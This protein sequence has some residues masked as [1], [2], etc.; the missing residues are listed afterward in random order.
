MGV[1]M[2]WL[3]IFAWFFPPLFEKRTPA[4]QAS[5]DVTA[6]EPEAAGLDRAGCDG[7]AFS[8]RVCAQERVG[9]TDASGAGVLGSSRGGSAAS[10]LPP[11]R[12]DRGL[13][14]GETLRQLGRAGG[15]GAVVAKGCAAAHGR[16]RRRDGRGLGAV[17]RPGGR[18][19]W[20][21]GVVLVQ[22]A[23]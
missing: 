22:L 5:V 10:P 18:G 12:R 2:R 3:G 16:S 1:S 19:C 8:P 20:W 23:R 14:S 17:V 21:V 7:C 9:F 13:R 11:R 4:A 6:A 15:V